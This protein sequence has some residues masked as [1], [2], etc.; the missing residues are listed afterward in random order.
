[1]NAHKLAIIIPAYKVTYL[2]ET[3]LS[4][5]K[6]SNLRFTVY[7]GDDASP[8]DLNVIIDQYREKLDIVYHRF[9]N[10]LGS[11]SLTK[12]WERS[13]GLSKEEWIWLF[14]DDDVIEK[15]AVQVFYDSYNESCKLYKFHTQVIDGNGAVNQY[16]AKFDNQNKFEDS[17]SSVDFIR[18]RL[19]CNGFRSFAVEYIFHRSFYER[20]KF[21]DFPLAWGSDDATWL[22]YSL[23]NNRQIN[24]LNA[25]V[26]WRYSGLNISSDSKSLIVVGKKIEA[27]VEYVKWVKTTAEASNVGL[28]DSL[29]LHWFSIQI[30]SL[31]SEINYSEFKQLIK[32]STLNTSNL[33][34]LLCY[35]SVIKKRRIINLLKIGK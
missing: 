14:S 29:I 24:L 26:Y 10:N 17:I 6:Q 23:A 27:A 30:A 4:L 11:V 33:T 34:L 8:Y 12:Q 1:M 16:Y 22:L 9:E 28:S 5:S 3:L 7:I 32:R 13:V 15:N 2:E 19:A 35:F 31:R 18:N 20:F 25:I 21:V